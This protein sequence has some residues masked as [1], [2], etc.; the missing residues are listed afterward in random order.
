MSLLIVSSSD[1]ENLL[2]ETPATEVVDLMRQVFVD[3]S[4]RNPSEQDKP[5]V[6]SPERTFVQTP[7]QTTLFMPSYWP[8]AGTAIKIVSVPKDSAQTQGLRGLPATTA[9]VN[10]ETGSVEAIV[11]ARALTALRTAAGSVLATSCLWTRAS[12]PPPTKLVLFGAGLQMV[13]HARLFMDPGMFGGSLQEVVVINR[14]DNERLRTVVGDL[15][16]RF[17]RLESGIKGMTSDWE[18]DVKTADIICTAT[19]SKELLFPGEWVKPGAH[20]NLTGSYTPEM[21]EVDGSTVNRADVVLVDSRE[22][23]WKEAGDLIQGGWKEGHPNK[24][25]LN[26]AIIEIGEFVGENISAEHKERVEAGLHDRSITIFKSVG[27]GVQDVAIASL[28]VR[29]AREKGSG[30]LVPYD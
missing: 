28:V 2:E 15:K 5:Q 30:T 21:R 19:S 16:K 8:P 9:V 25:K 29:L 26:A 4:K 7:H 24:V 27:V 1:V 14:S 10:A 13:F 20:L 23:C 22:A 11:N 17:P 6:Q 12:K 3:F 18:A